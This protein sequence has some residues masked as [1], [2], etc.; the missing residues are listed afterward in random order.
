MIRT[1]LPMAAVAA[2]SLPSTA[3]AC[4][5]FFCSREP[6]D[7]SK[8]R[9]VFA[10][11]ED[12]EEVETHAQPLEEPLRQA[13]EASQASSSGLFQAWCLLVL[14][15]VPNP[16]MAP[17]TSAREITGSATAWRTTSTSRTGA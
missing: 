13:R 2:M 9:I 6:I 14:G 10:I 12:K 15:L 1:L 8:E 3:F 16:S 4:G 5:G 17:A 11:D 7:Q